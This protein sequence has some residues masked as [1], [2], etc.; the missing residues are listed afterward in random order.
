MITHNKFKLR[1][2]YDV[3]CTDSMSYFSHLNCMINN[4]DSLS[5]N[6]TAIFDI[7]Y[8]VL[9]LAFGTEMG[10]ANWDGILHAFPIVKCDQVTFTTFQWHSLQQHVL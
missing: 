6:V 1:K 10:K 2:A 3:V 4:Y 9:K 8:P 5:M 7:W